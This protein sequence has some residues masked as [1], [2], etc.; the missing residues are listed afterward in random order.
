MKWRP[1]VIVSL[2]ACLI[3]LAAAQL[4]PASVPR[5][6]LKAVER[7]MRK[8]AKG[9]LPKDNFACL[10][11][12]P[13]LGDELLVAKHLPHGVTCAFCHGLS[14]DHRNDESNQTKADVLFGRAEVEPF[15][16][17]CHGKHDHPDKV[18][19]FLAE[20]QGTVRPNG[21]L[22]L[23]QAVC[24]DCHGAHALKGGA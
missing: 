4:S 5:A 21:R 12:H 3:G 15:C 16:R 24:T 6:K 2:A 10:V 9:A 11:C 18:N 8:R 1:A 22:I 20:C 14:S 17:K 23:G 19:A 7:E 13:N